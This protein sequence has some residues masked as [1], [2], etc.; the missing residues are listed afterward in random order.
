MYLV[1]RS[2]CYNM[3]STSLCMN[4]FR[5][6]LLYEQ[7][8]HVIYDCCFDAA[9]QTEFSFFA[10]LKSLKLKRPLLSKKNFVHLLILRTFKISY[11]LRY[12]CLYV[13]VVTS[14]GCN[15]FATYECFSENMIIYSF[16]PLKKNPLKLFDINMKP[17]ICAN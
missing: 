5:F 4:I 17:L 7:H 3:K 15:I 6:L 1:L 16:Y 2:R 10:S 11:S 14:N 13:Y 9:V 8:K 12:S